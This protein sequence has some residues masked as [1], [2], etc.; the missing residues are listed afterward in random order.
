[1]QV[2]FK[3]HY[4]HLSILHCFAVVFSV[5]HVNEFIKIFHSLINSCSFQAAY[6]PSV[7]ANNKHQHKMH[8]TKINYKPLKMHYRIND[9]AK[10]RTNNSP[11]DKQQS[12]MSLFMAITVVVN[13]KCNLLIIRARVCA[14]VW[15]G[16]V[17][18]AKGG[19][20]LKRDNR[21]KN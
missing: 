18:A 5:I 6:Y 19:S 16:F 14:F 13:I 20:T 21:K 11:K 1:M 17:Y 8:S 2:L 3:S 10:R 12:G 15:Y 7:E 9:G 4:L